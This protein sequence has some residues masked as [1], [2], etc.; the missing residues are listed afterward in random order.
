[1]V[2]VEDYGKLSLGL[3]FGT[4]FLKGDYG[5][6]SSP[7]GMA[8]AVGVGRGCVVGGGG[9]VGNVAAESREEGAQLRPRGRERS[10]ADETTHDFFDEPGTPSATPPPGPVPPAGGP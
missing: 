3:S 9:G 2:A 5:E 1:M 7:G 6:L 10:A 8:W 4:A